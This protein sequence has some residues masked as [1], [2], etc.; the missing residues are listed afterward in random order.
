MERYTR[1]LQEMLKLD[2]VY[3]PMNSGDKSAPKIDPQRFVWAVRGMPCL[4]AAISRDI[5]HSVIPYLDELDELARDVQSVNTI[6]V[7]NGRLKGYNTDALGFKLAIDGGL[8]ASRI[9]VQSAVVYGYG[10]VSSVVISVLKSFGFK[11]Y[12]TGRNKVQAA[13]IC[14]E[15][16]ALLWE[17]QHVELF[18][19]ATPV[20][21]QPLELADGFI[22]AISICKIAFDH[23]MPGIFMKEYCTSNGI[24]HISGDTMYYPQMT[25]QWSLFLEGLCD[26]SNISHMLEDASKA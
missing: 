18:V 12:V 10:G 24:F 26:I 2:I 15:F 23:E 7:R 16:D 3:L 20:T 9:E 25:A 19:N 5:K 1:L 22:Q 21:H 4:G 13:V 14:Q 17:G 6:V 8:A 11:V